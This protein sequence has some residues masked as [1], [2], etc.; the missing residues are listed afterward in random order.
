MTIA[1]R[2]ELIRQNSIQMNLAMDLGDESLEDECKEVP[3]I[4]ECSDYVPPKEELDYPDDE[5]NEDEFAEYY[6]ECEDQSDSSGE[7]EV[8]KYFQENPSDLGYVTFIRKYKNWVQEVKDYCEI[9][10]EKYN[11]YPNVLVSNRITYGRF[12]DSYEKYYR[13]NLEPSGE[14]DYRKKVEL[15]VQ[16]NDGFYEDLYPQDAG[17]CYFHTD[18]Y[19]LRMMEDKSFGSGVVQL[20]RVHGFLGNEEFP[21]DKIVSMARNV[22][23]TP[24]PVIN[25]KATGKHLEKIMKEE[26][27]TPKF[28]ARIMGWEKPQAIYRW[29][30][31]ETLPT[32]DTLAVLA[33]VLNRSVESLLIMNEIPR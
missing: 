27:V 21:E 11:V 25:M 31:G 12:Q 17:Q 1:E 26:G 15:G 10:K 14:A 13:G 3:P 20:L 32:L 24:H 2:E 22:E 28:F 33:R 19:K 18:K 4:E 29:Y 7:P 6:D 9:F 16:Y 23:K 8:S 5:D 30:Y